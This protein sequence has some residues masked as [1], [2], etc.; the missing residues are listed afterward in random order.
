MADPDPIIIDG[1]PV[2][3]LTVDASPS[4]ATEGCARIEVRLPLAMVLH[5]LQ[6]SCDPELTRE[7]LWQFL[8]SDARDPQGRGAYLGMVKAV[9]CRQRKDAM[10]DRVAWIWVDTLEVHEDDEAIVFVGTA[11]PT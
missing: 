2:D 1:A 6:Q 8:S 11:R 7:N 3:P 5:E 4:S 9:S 10:H